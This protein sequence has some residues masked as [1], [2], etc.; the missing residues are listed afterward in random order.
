MGSRTIDSVPPLPQPAKFESGDF[1]WP[2]KPG[3]FVPYTQTSNFNRRQDQEVWEREKR[4]FLNRSKKGTYLTQAQLEAI[5]DLDYRE[6]HARYH[7][8]QMP[9]TLGVYSSGGG[10]Y[11][12]HVGIVEVNPSGNI[13]IIEALSDRGV[14]RHSY[15]EW[16]AGRVG[17]IVWL[18]RLANTP[19]GDRAQI[20]TEA[21]K[22]VGRPYNF[23]NFDLD[24]DEDFYCSKLAWLSMF[25]SLGLAVD[26]NP[27]AKRDFWF[28]PKQLLYLS[29]ITR[30][31]DPG[32]YTTR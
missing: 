8:D 6:F 19:K 30:L 29:A 25:R 4:E 18:G 15:K 31:H 13:E 26:Q 17:E 10:L 2:K 11:V 12:G 1:V 32:S 23:W 3:V 21:G 22:Y 24:D 9:D 27:N 14:V 7:A 28:S 16:R 5:R 20:S